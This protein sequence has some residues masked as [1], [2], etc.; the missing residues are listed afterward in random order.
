MLVSTLVAFWIGVA[1]FF[2]GLGLAV[3]GMIKIGR[4]KGGLFGIAD[5]ILTLFLGGC[6]MTVGVVVAVTALGTTFFMNWHWPMMGG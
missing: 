3:S 1:T 6:I 2:L 4:S 5:G